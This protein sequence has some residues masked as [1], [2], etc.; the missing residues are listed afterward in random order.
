MSRIID[1]D[2]KPDVATDWGSFDKSEF[3]ILKSDEA[4]WQA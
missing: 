1:F 3:G 4:I 2:D